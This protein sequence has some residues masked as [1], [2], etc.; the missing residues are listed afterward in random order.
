[1]TSVPAPLRRSYVVRPT[2]PYPYPAR[3]AVGLSG[4]VALGG[5]GWRP[6]SSCPPTSCAPAERVARRGA[7][8]DRHGVERRV[9]ACRPRGSGRS[10]RRSRRA[11]G[12]PA[13]HG[14]RR[15]SAGARRW[16]LRASSSLAATCGREER[17]R[18]RGERLRAIGLLRL[19]V[20]H[21]IA[22]SGRPRPGDEARDPRPF[23]RRSPRAARRPGLAGRSA[24]PSSPSPRRLISSAPRAPIGAAT[25]RRAAGERGARRRR[26]RSRRSSAPAAR[27][28]PGRRDLE[29]ADPSAR[30][31][32]R[33]SRCPRRPPRRARRRASTD[34]VAA[35]VGR[36]RQQRRARPPRGR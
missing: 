17:P 23:Q 2:S 7:C 35:R 10:G 30:A 31:A 14:E 11:R 19:L 25:R 4:D 12:S 9:G 5:S 29:H 27:S 18:R 16:R 22:R 34:H 33:R 28:G 36:E 3:G 32:R 24:P 6:S 8:G 20:E 13:E 15:P 26:R 1:M 21:Q